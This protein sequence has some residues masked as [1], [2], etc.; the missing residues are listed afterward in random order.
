MRAGPPD[1]RQP[2]RGPLPH[3]PA[4]R[5]ARRPS[6]RPA[7]A[8]SLWPTRDLVLRR[9]RAHPRRVLPRLRAALGHG[10]LPA[11]AAAGRRRVALSSSHR[12]VSDS[13]AAAA[14]SSRP[15]RTATQSPARSPASMRQGPDGLSTL[16]ARAETPP[17]P[18]VTASGW[19]P[20][21]PTR[22]TCPAGGRHAAGASST[23]AFPAAAR[24]GP[25]CRRRSAVPVDRGRASAELGGQRL[26]QLPAHRRGAARRQ[27][28]RQLP[29]QV[30]LPGAD[31]PGGRDPA[32]L[33]A[34]P[35]SGRLHA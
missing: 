27:A 24:T 22:P 30:R 21:T 29:L 31:G 18:A 9:Q 23:C 5:P 16:L 11:L 25:S 34:L 32:R 6:R 10:S 26:L 7:A 19:R 1:V 15:A 35:A 2:R 33:R 13:H 8:S 12:P 28:V 4:Q 3:L 17:E 20:S 14:R